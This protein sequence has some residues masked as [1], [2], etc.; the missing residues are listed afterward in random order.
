MVI[1]DPVYVDICASLPEESLSVLLEKEY[2]RRHSITSVTLDL[3]HCVDSL[4]FTT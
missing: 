2:I 4:S 3:V 1:F